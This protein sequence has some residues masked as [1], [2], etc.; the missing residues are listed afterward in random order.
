MIN[1]EQNIQEDM[2][3]KEN[4][5]TEKSIK[6]WSERTQKWRYVPKDPAYFRLKYY[7]YVKPKTCDICSC[8]IHTQML[9]HYRTKKC[10][11]VRNGIN[12]A[13]VKIESAISPFKMEGT[14]TFTV[15]NQSNLTRYLEHSDHNRSRSNSSEGSRTSMF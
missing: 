10:Q 15:E 3:K 12:N 5:T 9:R 14:D 1:D 7:D 2:S 11:L 13:V 6:I 8:V 4:S